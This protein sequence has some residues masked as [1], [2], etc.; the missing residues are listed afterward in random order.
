MACH[1]WVTTVCTSPQ[2]RHNASAPPGGHGLQSEVTRAI[3]GEIGGKLNPSLQ[4]RLAKRRPI[5]PE[6]YEA[7]LKG[8]F[9][10]YKISK[11]GIED[12]E[13]YFQL[14]LEKDP[15]YALAYSGLA[16]VWVMR[17]DS[18][19]APPSET[20]PKAKVNAL[21]ALQLDD[22]LSESHLS[23]AILEEY[24]RDWAPAEQD[25]Q[26]AIQLNP[27]SADAHFMYADYLISLHRNQE[28]Q[29][30]M[31]RVFAV[32]PMNFFPRCFYGWHLIYLGRYDEAI[33]TLQNVL[34]TQPNFSSGH[35]GLWG[36]YYK[37]HLDKEA[38]QEAVRFF[39][40]LNDHEVAAALKSGYQQAGYR[41]GM[42]RAADT[43]SS[44]AQ[45]SYVPGVRI[46]RLYAHA[47][48]TD[49][50]ILW[51]QKAYEANETPLAHLGVAWDWDQLRSDP[52]FQDLIRRMNYP[53]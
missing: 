44:R 14:A 50:A 29:A 45:H 33:S 25:Y 20:M 6:A 38:W 23:L 43:L 1:F 52:R 36:A 2:A 11:Q 15:D 42:K 27:S 37:K 7:Y 46:A 24:E 51:L 48:D 34:A 53:Q 32:D 22:T 49:H 10:W 5:N 3:A 19:Y 4:P 28:W 9:Q 30:E 13:R 17:T 35:L 18:G 8:R 39:E 16:D 41:E 47:G 31:Q 26:R 12:A 40:T 21:K